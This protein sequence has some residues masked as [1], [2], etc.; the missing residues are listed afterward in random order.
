MPTWQQSLSSQILVALLICSVGC[1]SAA[2]AAPSTPAVAPTALTVPPPPFLGQWNGFLEITYVFPLTGQMVTDIC[3]HRWTVDMQNGT[4]FS[5]TYS[6][7]GGH[8]T[9]PRSEGC[10]SS[11]TFRG[12]TSALPTA[13]VSGLTYNSILGGASVNLDC[14]AVSSPVFSGTTN[15]GSFD[16]QATDTIS[17]LVAGSPAHINRTLTVHGDMIH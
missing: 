2:P 14:A 12:N 1:S 8:T 9:L 15:G 3:D 10:L 4:A 13:S 5:G 16:A 7:A 17:C 6:S 11:G